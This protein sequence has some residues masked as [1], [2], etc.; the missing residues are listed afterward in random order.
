MASFIVKAGDNLRQEQLAM[1]VMRLMQSIFKE[2]GLGDRLHLRPYNI[3]TTGPKAGLIETVVDSRSID[4]VKKTAPSYVSLRDF[5]ERIY[6][7]PGFDGGQG[8]SPYGPPPS[9]GQPM[10]YGA[11]SMPFMNGMMGAQMGGQIGPQ[12]YGGGMGQQLM[13]PQM[14]S[15]SGAPPGVPS[16]MA[17]G[18]PMAGGSPGVPP[19]GMCLFRRAQENFAASLAAYSLFTYLLQVC[20]TPSL[21]IRPCLCNFLRC[22]C[23]PSSCHPDHTGRHFR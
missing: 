4:H 23:L 2:E 10:G 7:P 6:G 16:S 3:I 8:G 20:A 18:G 13:G 5:Y 22:R 19:G 11:N 15:W 17:S 21:A 1:Q 9:L 14:T 12:G